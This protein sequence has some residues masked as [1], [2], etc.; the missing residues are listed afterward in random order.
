MPRSAEN[1]GLETSGRQEGPPYPH[2]SQDGAWAEGL[3]GQSRTPP[4][5]Q[6][7]QV[8]DA[9]RVP[10]QGLTNPVAGA[11]QTPAPPKG[12]QEPNELSPSA[13]PC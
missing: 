8:T 7:P 2:Q 13:R 9:L 5:S 11:G 6:G 12:P 4:I 1:Q 10:A 3:T